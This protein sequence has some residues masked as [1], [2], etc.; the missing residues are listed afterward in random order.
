MAPSIVPGYGF[1]I[2]LVD[3]AHL[4]GLGQEPPSQPL[5]KWENTGHTKQEPGNLAM[6]RGK[7]PREPKMACLR[8]IF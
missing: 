5:A 3:S 8:N 4:L 1:G 7:K 6:D 2:P